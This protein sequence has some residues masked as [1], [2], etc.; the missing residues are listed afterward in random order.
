MLLSWGLRKV[1]VVGQLTVIDANGRR[2]AFVGDGG[3]SCTVRLR[4]RSLHRTLVTNPWLRV[5]EAY[6]DGTLTIEQGDLY[7]FVELGAANYRN[8]RNHVQTARVDFS[9]T[10]SQGYATAYRDLAT[11]GETTGSRFAAAMDR[12]SSRRGSESSRLMRSSSVGTPRTEWLFEP[13]T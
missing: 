7:D 2:H 6:M 1:I 3:P 13:R 12:S 8:A 9:I 10:H 11:S 4:D 5:G